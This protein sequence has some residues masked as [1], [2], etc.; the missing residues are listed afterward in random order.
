M[1]LEEPRVK[2]MRMGR[3]ESGE[4]L[5]GR[6][7]AR[8]MMDEAHPSYGDRVVILGRGAVMLRESP[9]SLR[10]ARESLFLRVLTRIN[11]GQADVFT[12]AEHLVGNPERFECLAEAL[13][14]PGFR[15]SGNV[16][17]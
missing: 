16:P 6:H 12:V 15:N 13:I 5:R 7:L 3:G 17:P 11:P 1:I 9:N 10:H 14:G 4:V 8:G 2:E